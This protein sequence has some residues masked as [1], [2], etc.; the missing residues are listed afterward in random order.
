MFA[1]AINVSKKC[2]NA[3]LNFCTRSTVILLL[4]FSNSTFR[5]LQVNIVGESQKNAFSWYLRCLNA[6]WTTCVMAVSGWLIAD[7]VRRSRREFN[8]TRKSSK[9]QRYRELSEREKGEDD[10]E[11]YL[12]NHRHDCLPD[13][14]QSLLFQSWSSPALSFIVSKYWRNSNTER[15]WL[16][17]FYTEDSFIRSRIRWSRS[18]DESHFHRTPVKACL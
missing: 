4:L 11:G 15:K 18:F 6:K 5:G 12:S 8:N 1:W 7:R 9:G 17:S 2:V 10:R 13:N 16:K 14:A 3:N